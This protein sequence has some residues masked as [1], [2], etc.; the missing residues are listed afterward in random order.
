MT[1]PTNQRL[2]QE[3]D[4]RI[5]LDDL[6]ESET[7]S[8]PPGAS[9]TPVP[10]D[11]HHIIVSPLFS[12]IDKRNNAAWP[13][14][15]SD[16]TLTTENLTTSPS[17]ESEGLRSPDSNST[18]FS[19]RVNAQRS[20]TP[21]QQSSQS[22]SAQSSLATRKQLPS[23]RQLAMPLGR[24][25]SLKPDSMQYG[26]PPLHSHSSPRDVDMRETRPG[27]EPISSTYTDGPDIPSRHPG[28]RPPIPQP[29]ST[30][31]DL[32]AYDPA[33]PP[34]EFGRHRR[35]SIRHDVALSPALG[36]RDLEERRGE[37]DERPGELEI[38]KDCFRSMEL[39][40]SEGFEL[41]PHWERC[42]VR[43]FR[44]E[45]G[46]A[47]VLTL[48]ES[49]VD[50][51][52]FTLKDTEIVPEYGYHNSDSSPVIYLR[53]STADKSRSSV[54]TKA[55]G[56]DDPAAASL[57]YR[58]KTA[59]DMFNFQLAFTGERVELDMKGIRTVRYKRNLLDGEHSQY[60]ARIQLWREQFHPTV[61][62]A[63]EPPYPRIASGTIRSRGAASSALKY[64]NTR[65]VIYF[66]EIMVFLFGKTYIIFYPSPGLLSWY[67]IKI[68]TDSIIIDSRAR[69]NVIRI[70]PSSWSKFRNP[71]SV[72]A[73]F[74][75]ARRQ[76]GGFQLDKKGLTYECEDGFEEFKWFE[77][78][79]DSS[80][81]QC[82]PPCHRPPKL[83][84]F[85]LGGG[86]M[87]WANQKNN[88][89][90][91]RT[92]FFPHRF[93][94]RHWRSTKGTWPSWRP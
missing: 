72:R 4:L 47:R 8:Q 50:Y 68:V 39:S 40:A 14:A 37:L 63:V 45:D 73:C 81:G 55:P 43:I 66:E 82:F 12:N 70:K 58:F 25:Q 33:N 86:G 44:R 88:C 18:T 13:H 76:S 38:M 64:A 2:V 79:F 5:W 75:G 56:T 92:S 59:S 24:T 69:T 93:Q 71:S 49:K 31:S 84:F 35:Q 57:Y 21:S 26:V 16:I 90:P 78:D 89:K 85:F 10:D 60:K 83:S 41:N 20:S 54:I 34:S 42:S 27:S 15:G 9:R 1:L 30:A 29:L 22:S 74:L 17:Q 67:P 48:L 62:G 94:P 11:N 65:L 51:R 52:Y 23:A 7:E 46:S 53:K 3:G 80:E 87:A 32:E 36:F 61:A 6:D 19:S 91:H 28:R 77:L